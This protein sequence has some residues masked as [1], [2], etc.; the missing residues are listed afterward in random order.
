MTKAKSPVKVE[1]PARVKTIVVE[2]DKANLNFNVSEDE[3]A[4]LLALRELPPEAKVYVLAA[5][6]GM[7]SHTAAHGSITLSS[8]ANSLKRAVRGVRHKTGNNT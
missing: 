3:R 7:L 4:M 8:V 2:I 1:E 6:E 5:I